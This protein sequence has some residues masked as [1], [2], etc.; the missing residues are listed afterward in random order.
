MP[1]SKRICHPLSLSLAFLLSL[2][3]DL[4]LCASVTRSDR[5]SKVVRGVT[6]RADEGLPVWRPP[7]RHPS[8]LPRQPPV[9]PNNAAHPR[10]L[11][12]GV[13]KP[14]GGKKPPDH[15]GKIDISVQLL[16]IKLSHHKRPLKCHYKIFK[17]HTWHSTLCTLL[18][19]RFTLL[20]ST[21]GLHN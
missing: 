10:R 14:H 4:S 19:I 1:V 20:L 9:G 21:V 8:Q 17:D 12:R 2:C 3:L 16:V 7:A 5:E 11:R 18:T 13:G 15:Q 6:L